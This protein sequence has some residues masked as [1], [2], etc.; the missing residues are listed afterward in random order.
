MARTLVSRGKRKKQHQSH[1]KKLMGSRAGQ[2]SAKQLQRAIDTINAEDYRS[3]CE[4]L[5]GLSKHHPDDVDVLH[6]LGATCYNLRDYDD[7]RLALEKR[8]G[9]KPNT[10]M[11]SSI[12]RCHHVSESHYFLALVDH[13]Q[14]MYDDA[15]EKLKILEKDSSTPKN[16]HYKACSML[17]RTLHVIGENKEAIHYLHWCLDQQPTCGVTWANL[18]KI[19]S[20]DNTIDK[21][22]DAHYKA[23]EYSTNKRDI[24]HLE[25]SLVSLLKK[26]G[27]EENFQKRYQ[28]LI[29]E[30]PTYGMILEQALYLPNIYQNQ[31]E[32]IDY[33][34]RYIQNLMA[35]LQ[36]APEMPN[37]HN[38]VCVSLTFLLAYH[39]ESDKDLMQALGHLIHNG[40]KPAPLQ[41]RP[42]R[43]VGQKIRVGIISR[44]WSRNHTIGKLYT[45]IFENLN[46]DEF[47]VVMFH[48]VPNFHPNSHKGWV[49]QG[50]VFKAYLPEQDRPLSTAIL[51]K[52]E[53]DILFYTDIGMDTMTYFQAFERVA[54]AQCVTFGHPSTS[55]IPNMDYFFSCKHMESE[56]ARDY[57][58]EELIQL[59]TVPTY[60]E[61]PVLDRTYDKAYFGYDESKNHYICPQSLFKMHPDID[62]IFKGILE[63]DP[64]GILVMLAGQTE[65]WKDQLTERFE[66]TIGKELMERI[67]WQGRVTRKDFV[68]MMSVC[69][70]MLDPIHF[71]GG[72]TSYEALAFGTP[73]VT[74]PG[75]YL[76]SKI[77]EAAYHMMGYTEL[78]T[79]SYQAFVDK[80]VEIGTNPAKRMEV[81]QMILDRCDVLYEN[82]NT[83]REIEEQFKRMVAV[84]ESQ[85]Y[86]NG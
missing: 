28:K 13:E 79:D 27:D 1:Q 56:N 51:K 74:C 81:S 11:P 29:D 47:E 21:A 6:L 59:D 32:V 5:S 45:G 75:L 52:A 36:D 41:P 86:Y 62:E 82:D 16:T 66:R 9:I 43:V 15:I 23:L 76:K 35:L 24:R 67:V 18:A 50:N 83:I 26:V 25:L 40:Y 69:E 20:G 58:T 80:A 38:E 63:K 19:Y 85:G 3:A 61:K 31:Q 49:Q 2:V 4:L 30:H 60:Y 22:I 8:I 10:G 34:N 65:A 14:G 12:A 72:N 71:G 84:A 54:P 42:K 44:F 70:V 73:V 68:G 77:T 64:D 46:P 78:I 55:G 53:L 48:V 39:G 33:R 7:A 17:G 57:Y 37:L